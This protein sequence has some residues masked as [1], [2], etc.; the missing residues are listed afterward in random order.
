[1]RQPFFLFQRY[2]AMRDTGLRSFLGIE[3]SKDS[4]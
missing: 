2:A 3:I 1:M 4:A